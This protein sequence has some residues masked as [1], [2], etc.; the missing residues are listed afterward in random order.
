MFT[1]GTKEMCIL[2]QSSVFE[3]D[4]FSAMTNNYINM[5]IE[6]KHIKMLPKPQCLLWETSYLV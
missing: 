6:T 3:S 4:N 5:M 2:S 1:F